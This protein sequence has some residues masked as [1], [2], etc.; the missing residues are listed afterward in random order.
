MDTILLSL[1]Q[2]EVSI[3][4]LLAIGFCVGFLSGLLG[5]GGGWLI[6]PALNMIGMPMTFAIGT[7][8]AQMSATSMFAAFRH[9]KRGN[10]DM[11]LGL[12]IG[13][14]MVLGVQYGKTLLLAMEQAGSADSVTRNLYIVL[15]GVMGITM[16]R[17]SLQTRKRKKLSDGK[18]E[19]AKAKRQWGSIWGPTTYIT[20]ADH[21]LPWSILIGLGL[22]GGVLSGLLGVGGGFMLMPAMIYL[23]G[24]S[25]L[26]AVATS[27]ICVLIA[28]LYGTI[29]FGLS[30]RVDFQAVGILLI[31]SLTGSLLGVHSTEHIDGDGLKTVFAGLVLIAAFSIGLTQLGYNDQARILVFS[32]AALVTLGSIFTV[33]VSSKKG[34]DS[35]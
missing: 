16:M 1:S 5:V 6:T 28:S 17:D 34:H 26:Q 19:E 23:L 22:I 30:H 3:S 14:P 7:G 12:S 31:G 15:L 11:K 9:R 27:L 2:I 24:V 32:A 10:A 33:F 13:L 21:N 20:S 4:L 29:I 8:L 25:T 18:Q 35:K